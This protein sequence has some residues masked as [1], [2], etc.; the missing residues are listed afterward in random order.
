MEGVTNLAGRLDAFT[1][2]DD[3]HDVD[4]EKAKRKV[5]L[6]LAGSPQIRRDPQHAMT[7]M[8]KS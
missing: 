7:A 4:K 1:Q 2:A 3:D 8:V 5:P 6:N